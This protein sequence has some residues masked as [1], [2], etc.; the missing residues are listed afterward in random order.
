MRHTKRAAPV[1]ALCTKSTNQTLGK[2]MKI[3]YYITDENLNVCSFDAVEYRVWAYQQIVSRY[4]SADVNVI[5]QPYTN[6]VWCSEASIASEVTAF[7]EALLPACK[8]EWV[9]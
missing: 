9:Y 3:N 1:A 4:P 7:V 5:N 6:G 2:H 8:W